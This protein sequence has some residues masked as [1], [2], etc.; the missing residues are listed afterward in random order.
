MGKFGKRGS[1]QGHPVIVPSP[2]R[3]RVVE[4]RGNDLG[5]MKIRSTAHRARVGNHAHWAR[6]SD[7]DITLHERAMSRHIYQANRK[8]QVGRIVGGGEFEQCRIV[9]NDG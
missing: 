1:G 6:Q 7:N 2:P 9:K 3:Y 5:L 4:H 8:P